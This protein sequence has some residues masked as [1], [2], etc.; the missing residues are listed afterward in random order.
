MDADT[1]RYLRVFVSSTFLDMVADRDYLVKRTFPALRKMCEERGVVWS[2]VDL[3]WGIPDERTAEGHVLPICLAEIERSRPFFIGLLGERYGWVPDAIPA[4][5]D[6]SAPW[7]TEHRGASITELEILHGVLRNPRMQSRGFFYFRSPLRSAAVA[8][9]VSMPAEPETSSGKLLRLKER[10][11]AGQRSGHCSL[12]EN[13]ESPE[14]LGRWITE[15]FRALFDDLYPASAD[16][17][18]FEQDRRAQAAFA[19]A[20]TRAYV[21]I[22]SG[23]EALDRHMRN[24]ARGKGIVVS[25]AP[26]AGKSALLAA[27][28]G[29]QALSTYVLAHYVEASPQSSD[30]ASMLR[31]LMRE[32]NHRFDLQ[33]GIPEAGS[34][35]GRAFNALLEACSASVPSPFV[36]LIDGI[37]RLGASG[38]AAPTSWLPLAVPP[39]VRI[40]V[41]SSAEAMTSSLEREGWDRLALAP[42]SPDQRTQLATS[43][44]AEYS[45][46]LGSAQMARVVANPQTGNP[47]YLRTLLD[48]LRVFG[49]HARLDPEIDRYLA[50]DSVPALCQRVLERCERD[51]DP[52]GRGIVRSA[53]SLIWASHGGLAEAE[54]LDLLGSDGLPLPRAVWSPIFLALEGSLFDR[55]GLLSCA[56]EYFRCAVERAYIPTDADRTKLHTRLAD[57]FDRDAAFGEVSETMRRIFE[58]PASTPTPLR[59]WAEALIPRRKRD[60]LPWQVADAAAWPRLYALF[61]DY[62]FLAALWKADPA[63]VL[64]LWDRLER[65]EGY[66]RETAY[67][68][69]VDGNEVPSWWSRRAIIQLLEARRP[70]LGSLLRAMETTRLTQSSN[71]G[72]VLPE[73]MHLDPEFAD[74]MIDLFTTDLASRPDTQDT[75]AR[76]MELARIAAG[77]GRRQ[78]LA[79][80]WVQIARVRTARGEFEAVEN[81]LGKAETIAVAIHDDILVAE[82]YTVRAGALAAR[83]ETAQAFAALEAQRGICRRLGCWALLARGLNIAAELALREGNLQRGLELAREAETLGR[84]HGMTLEVERASYAQG[85]ALRRRGERTE[86]AERMRAAEACLRGELGLS[87]ID[88]VLNTRLSE[89]IVMQAILATELGDCATARRLADDAAQ[90]SRRF[91]DAANRRFVESS[92][93]WVREQCP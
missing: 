65:Q 79:R 53:L 7:L 25:G 4:E 84:E 24:A 61:R 92:L 66:S 39:N 3:R 58:L 86:A 23:A 29:T 37:D 75:R 48:E 35:L 62:E 22:G 63:A 12:R 76:F 82:I 83:Q 89:N 6:R 20:R 1:P 59:V 34:A 26:G 32:L 68:G 60:E 77:L 19:R 10:I 11:R 69:V 93:K 46:E 72:A 21:D 42:L 91:P 47:L 87:P 71:A 40:V 90:V 28:A 64:A 15:D 70:G 43:Y 38:G 81:V 45:K 33:H 27:W 74:W 36:V 13:Y 17:D 41:S 8:K 44:L 30:T 57:Y 16:L 14:M 50:A 80:I 49:S 78:A 5:L 73:G 55:D 9:E 67:A 18:G 54:V 85:I 88:E 2:D 56:H 51:Y 31:R 52:E